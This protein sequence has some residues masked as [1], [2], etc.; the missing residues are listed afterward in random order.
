VVAAKSLVVTVA[1]IALVTAA[2]AVADAPTVRIARADQVRAVAALLRLGDIGTGWA[3]GRTPTSKLS[4]PSCPGFDPKE[5]DLVVT[6]HANARFVN[7]AAHATLAQDVQVLASERAVRTDFARTIRPALARCLAYQLRKAP[8]VTGVTVERLRFPDVGTVSA[9][10][11]ATVVVR[12]GGRKVTL[13][14]DYVFVGVGRYEFALNVLAPPAVAD[15]LVNFET[16]MM[17]I[18]IK[19]VGKPCC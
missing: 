4:A 12:D 11:R 1:L 13:Y 18:L 3:G 8:N 2:A 19:R 16:A 6:G 17:R 15:Q 5:S 14:D 9:A 7:S 10:Y